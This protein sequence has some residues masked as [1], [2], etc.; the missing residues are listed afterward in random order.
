M[1]YQQWNHQHHYQAVPESR[2]LLMQPWQHE[3]GC[4]VPRPRSFSLGSRP[5]GQEL[6]QVSTK[7]MYDT[8]PQIILPVDSNQNYC[9]SS[10]NN[11]TSDF[12][13]KRHSRKCGW[14]LVFILLLASGLSVLAWWKL[15]RSIVLDQEKDYPPVP[16]Q[17]HYQPPPPPP[18]PQQQQQQQ[19]AYHPLPPPPAALV[20]PGTQQQYYMPQQPTGWQQPQQQQQQQHYQHVPPVPVEAQRNYQPQQYQQQQYNNPQ[21][22]YPQQY[23]QPHYGQP[24]QINPHHAQHYANHQPDVAHHQG[25]QVPR[26]SWMME[27]VEN[28]VAQNEMRHQQQQFQPQQPQQIHQQPQQQSQQSS[29]PPPPPPP[30]HVHH[31]QQQQPPPMMEPVLSRQEERAKARNQARTMNPKKNSSKVQDDD[32]WEEKKVEND[33]IAVEIPLKLRLE[34]A[35][36]SFTESVLGNDGTVFITSFEDDEDVTVEVIEEA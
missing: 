18:V 10:N 35:L 34:P 32:I 36:F 23:Q 27:H 19:S 33:E 6:L 14:A 5:T 29:P 11:R 4:P 30:P 17:Q 28:P 20:P 25:E 21:H 15:R 8:S 1:T 7:R 13:S 12:K 26:K 31:Q 16:A 2:P 3:F 24:P 22:S 9:Y